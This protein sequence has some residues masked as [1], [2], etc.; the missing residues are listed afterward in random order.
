[1]SVTPINVARVSQN[2]RSFNLMNT[3]Q[4]RH[5]ELFRVQNQLA[6]GLRFGAPSEDPVRAADTMRLDR[7]LDIL[8]QVDSN[9]LRVNETL[10]AGETA[11]QEA[12]DIVREAH[13][14][15]LSMAGD[16]NSP[17]ERESMRV[18]V[19]SLLDQLVAVGNR[20]HIDS[21]LFAGFSGNV[22]FEIT[23][24]GVQFNGDNGRRMTI[25]DSDLSEDYFTISGQE[26]FNGVSAQVVGQ[27]DLNPALTERTRISDLAGTSGKGVQLGRI[28][29]ADGNDVATIDLTGAA[30]IGDVLDKLNEE[31]PP[32][33]QATLSPKGIDIGPAGAAA[34]AVTVT[35]ASGAHA[36]IDLGIHSDAPR[37]AINGLDLNPKL[38][39][40]TDLAALNAGAGL[41][42]A[43][44][45]TIRNGSSEAVVGFQ[46]AQTI[47]DVLNRINGSGT[48]V[49]AEIDENGAT[50]NVRSRVSGTTLSIGENGASAATNLGIRSL[51]SEA[52]LSELNDGRGIDTVDG[53][54]FRITTSD[55]T[56][57]DIDL[58]TLDLPHARV[59]DVLDLINAQA[60]GAVTAAFATNGNG[61]RIT[62]NTAGGG[63]LT[64]EALNVSPAITDL[65][66]AVNA[67]GGQ[68][69]GS[70]VNPV[71]VDNAFTALLELRTALENDDAQ[72]ISAAGQRL[73]RSLDGMLEV[74]GRLGAQANML[75]ERTARV[76]DERT[77]T[78]V[79]QSDV[80]D[81]D[82]TEAIVRFQQVQTALEANFA[83]S[84]RVLGLSLLDYLR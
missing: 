63:T 56:Q 27:R 23:K 2:L 54:D 62:D 72:G 35:D 70:D 7:Y 82:M 20:R 80:R 41:N 49:L 28:N 22:P 77:A 21:Y 12:V 9:L 44:G 40:R 8:D 76:T 38:S 32:T 16:V 73:S 51:N 26:F 33:L 81:V 34:V 39:L 74:Q 19:D 66:L 50:I 36:A 47:E 55:G 64:I 46:G 61:L 45:I 83:S 24:D 14:L 60:G 78:Q 10:R 3:V 30:T 1:M 58:D 29:V 37:V 53:D 69:V 31:M 11:M 79:L 68:L 25:V 17:G 59:Q 4:T 48:G 71:V 75:L 43:G 84:S 5:L 13:D 67:T 6:T 42:L 52:R 57:I 18:V 65:G 15:A